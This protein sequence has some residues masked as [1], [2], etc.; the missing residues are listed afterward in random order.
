MPNGS[1]ALLD[2]DYFGP[3]P[4]L[5]L[6]LHQLEHLLNVVT[7]FAIDRTQLLFRREQPM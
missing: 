7:G 5:D 4:R 6:R 3:A 2:Y 1:V